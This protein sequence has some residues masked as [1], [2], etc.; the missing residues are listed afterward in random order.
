[1]KKVEYETAERGSCRKFRR[2]SRKA[3]YETVERG[4]CR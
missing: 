3:K 2:Q 1:M 4:S